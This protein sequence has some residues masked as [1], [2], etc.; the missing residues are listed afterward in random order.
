MDQQMVSWMHW[1]YWAQDFGKP[2][3]YGLVNDPSKEPT[4]SNVKQ[5]LLTILTW[6]S[7]R[8]IA[9]T[10]QGWNWNSS[11]STFTAA[12]STARAA[13]GGSF[14]AGA[15]ST[16]FVHPRFFPNGYQVQVTGG[17]VVSAANAAWLQIAA[18]AGANSVTLSV[19][20]A[21]VD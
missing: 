2:S 4:G 12:Y 9:G 3:T 8:L 17:K 18:L 7:P 14:P 21:A 6:P 19:T 1:A 5:A 13:D 16:F 15:V 10:P 11:A 20:P